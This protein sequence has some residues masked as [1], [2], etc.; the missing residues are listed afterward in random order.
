VGF[1]QQRETLLTGDIQDEGTYGPDFAPDWDA[2]LIADVFPTHT[3]GAETYTWRSDGGSFP[4][5][6]LDYFAYTDSVV[7]AAKNFILWTPDMSPAELSAAGLLADDSTDASDHVPVVLDLV[8]PGA[9]IPVGLSLL[10]TV[11]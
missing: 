6:R 1:A 2:S 7:T 8:I 5:G 10:G 4:P 11:E 3:T 9:T